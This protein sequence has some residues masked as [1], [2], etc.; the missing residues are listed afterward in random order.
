LEHFV[1]LDAIQDLQ[2]DATAYSSLLNDINK[3]FLTHS[4]QD[5]LAEASVA[6][7]HA[8]S[9][10]EMREALESKIQ[11]LWDDMVEALGALSRKKDVQEGGPISDP[12][13]TDLANTVTR[14]SNLAGI[15]DCTSILETVPSTRS[16]SKKDHPEAPFN[17][18]IH[19]AGRGVRKD[20]EDEET[21]QTE[22]EL[23][24]SSLRTLLFYFMWKVQAL[25][26]ALNDGKASFTT[27]YFE[28]LTKGREMFASTLTKIMEKRSG[29]DELR[30]TAT[31]TFLDLQTL[32]STLRN[33]GQGNGNDE[34]V[35]FQT[36]SLVHEIGPDAQ[37]LLTKIHGIAERTFAK[38]SGRN[39]D[40]ADEDAPEE[41]PED[42]DE[43]SDEDNEDDESVMN[44]RLRSTIVAEQRLCELTG[45]LVLAI[46][47]RIVDASG[48]RRGSLKKRLLRNK[49]ALG[50]NY[51][52]VLSYLEERKPRSA[53]KS[54][55]KQP[56]KAAAVGQ[57]P[58]K[59]GAIS[60]ELVGEEDDEEGDG[61]RPDPMEEDEEEDLRARG[62]V[63]D[64]I[65]RADD[66]MEDPN[67]PVPDPDEDE[68][69][70]G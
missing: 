22:A 9:S 12:T 68:V 26:T 58:G 38:K 59:K 54:R 27:S 13:L 19:L 66:D 1:D 18:L 52:E 70:G 33:V 44:E 48:A 36:Q 64:D 61:E 10:D 24:T 23:V 7:L 39:I 57:T 29:F 20:D 46:I 31:T 28:A 15:T 34:D 32:F 8:K 17:T 63:E 16:K 69:M 25:A 50:Q 5:V 14:I 3:Q 41:D 67:T 42:E 56:A 43:A 11:E 40:P 65:D 2:K 60:A 21:V 49:T 47:A 35:V 51:R 30:F 6:F 37:A 53:P 4:D 45:K 55:A 62:L